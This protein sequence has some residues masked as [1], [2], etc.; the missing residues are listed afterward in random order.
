MLKKMQFLHAA[1]VIG[2]ISGMLTI[3]LISV[4]ANP[5]NPITDRQNIS[6]ATVNTTPA[7][8]TPMGVAPTPKTPVTKTQLIKTAPVAYSP[9]IDTVSGEAETALAE[10]LATTDAQFYGAYWCSYCQKQK[11]LFGAEAAAKLPYIECA[12]NAENTQ[13]KLCKEKKLKLFPTWIVKGKL[14]PGI[15]DLKELAEMTGYKG[16]TNFLY[17]K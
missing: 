8:Q 17:H 5:S 11:S 2:T 10:Y 14:Y 4:R 9:K 6:T 15:K 16:P 1:T 12:E 3:P 13:K 7:A